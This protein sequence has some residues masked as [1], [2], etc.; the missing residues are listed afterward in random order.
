M[1][2]HL[3]MVIRMDLL[4]ITEPGKLRC[5]SA[6]HQG[7]QPDGVALTDLHITG[8]HL[9]LRLQLGFKHTTYILGLFCTC[10]C[11]I[12]EIKW[13]TCRSLKLCFLSKFHKVISVIIS[14][15]FFVKLI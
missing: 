6:S 11:C 7:I 8:L 4:V 15:N 2:P 13:Q 9:E 5:R 14:F 10:A 12:S 1:I 3:V